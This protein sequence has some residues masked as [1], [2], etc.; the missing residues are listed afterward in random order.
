MS[1][2]ISSQVAALAGWAPKETLYAVS[3]DPWLRRR[4]ESNNIPHSTQ[5][6]HH[7]DSTRAG[8]KH[9]REMMCSHPP[10]LV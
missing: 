7:D 4:G 2:S 3:S 1:L 9:M 8:Q 6:R 10:T 5:E